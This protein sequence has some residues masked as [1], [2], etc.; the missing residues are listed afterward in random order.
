MKSKESPQR[1]LLKK[2]ESDLKR[3]PDWLR[4][5]DYVKRKKIDL[6]LKESLPR[7]PLKRKG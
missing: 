4:K 6:R 2:R 5:R 1:R 7:K 3:K